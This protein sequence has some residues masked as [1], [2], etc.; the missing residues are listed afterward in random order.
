MIVV[1]V[2]V[3]D[4]DTPPDAIVGCGVETREP[5]IDAVVPITFFSLGLNLDLSRLIDV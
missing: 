3:A 1:V 4:A 2:V 5:V